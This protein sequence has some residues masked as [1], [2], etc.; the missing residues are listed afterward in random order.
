M[1]LPPPAPRTFVRAG[2]KRFM[3]SHDQRTRH[4]VLEGFRI[5]RVQQLCCFAAAK[6]R[7]WRYGTIMDRQDAAAMLIRGDEIPRT[8]FQHA[9]GFSAA[10]SNEACPSIEMS[11]RR[12]I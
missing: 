12:G 5:L 1:W 7:R 2:C 8:R 9:S 11:R 10:S 4:C 3:D 6:S